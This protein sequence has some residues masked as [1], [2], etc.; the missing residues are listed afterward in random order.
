[1]NKAH[2]RDWRIAVLPLTVTTIDPSWRIKMLFDGQC[3]LCSR[4]V[5]MLRKRDARGLIAFEDIAQPGFDAGRYGL[6]MPQLIGSMHA[7]RRDGSIVQGV[8]VFAEVYDAVGWKLLARLIRWPVTRPL[9]KLGYRIFAAIRP[10]LSRFDPDRCVSGT[11][12]T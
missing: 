2:A 3:P 5:A 8:D 7:V 1:M 10:K 6:T 9:A 4:E 11:C 12:K